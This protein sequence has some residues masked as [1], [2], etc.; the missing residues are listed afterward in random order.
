MWGDGEKL[1]RDV[2][3]GS[4]RFVFTPGNGADVIGDFERGQ[5]DI[6]LTAFATAGIHDFDD[7][8]LVPATTGTMIDFDGDNSVTVLGVT[9]L[10]YGDFV[11]A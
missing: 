8:T 2:K 1:G 4:D 5:D 10:S 6:D 7:L 9:V 3:T 11:F